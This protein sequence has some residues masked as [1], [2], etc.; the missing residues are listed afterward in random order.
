MH[1]L[2]NHAFECFVCD[3]FGA[4][5]WRAITQRAG[6]PFDRFE[7]LL[8]YPRETTKALIA[9][10]ADWLERPAET[11]LEDMGTWLVSPRSG[12]RLRRLLRFG[13]VTFS[14]FLISLEE[15]PERARLAL[16]D[17]VLPELRLIEEGEG[18][19]LLRLREPFAGALHMLVGLLRAMADDYGALVVIEGEAGS[20]RIRLL[21]PDHGEARHFAL[22][23]VSG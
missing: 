17:L 9:A 13:G 14:D 8:F 3:T 22:A 7:P 5:D 21:D 6:L 10:A 18:V 23:A 20:I 12:G 4:A 11:L 19:F 16:P 2:V 15:V 1:G